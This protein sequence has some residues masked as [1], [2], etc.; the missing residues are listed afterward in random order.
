MSEA[1]PPVSQRQIWYQK[2]QFSFKCTTDVNDVLHVLC[3]KTKKNISHKT[4]SVVRTPT[5]PQFLC[6]YDNFDSCILIWK[7]LATYLLKRH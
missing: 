7:T 3:F 6:G 2:R 5:K 1:I 4:A